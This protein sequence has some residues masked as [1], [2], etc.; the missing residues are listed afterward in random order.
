MKKDQKIVYFY[1]FAKITFRVVNEPSLASVSFILADLKQ[2]K[3]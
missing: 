1:S 2:V 3:K